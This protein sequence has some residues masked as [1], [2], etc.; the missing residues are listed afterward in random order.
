MGGLA[1][2]VNFI[3]LLMAILFI[4]CFDIMSS[5][6][7]DEEPNG[8]V[9]GSGRHQAPSAKAVDSKGAPSFLIHLLFSLATYLFCFTN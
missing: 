4:F 3:L 8:S 6:A 1:A 5:A 9:E 7:L 2:H